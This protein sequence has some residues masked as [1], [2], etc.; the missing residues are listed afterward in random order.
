MSS[1][2][3]FDN[4]DNNFER[5]TSSVLAAQPP[6][7]H[8]T[9]HSSDPI[10]PAA[11]YSADVTSDSDI[12]KGNNERRFGAGTDDTAVMAGG[13]HTAD[14]SQWPSD[15]YQ[16]AYHE[17]RPLNVQPTVAGESAITPRS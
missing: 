1:V 6:P 12:W 8:H 2:D 5:N 14:S 4:F 17:E 9:H 7:A 10:Q 13:Q 11:N 15:D 3:S 16:N